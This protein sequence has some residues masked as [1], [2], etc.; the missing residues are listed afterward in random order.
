MI[1]TCDWGDGSSRITRVGAL[2]NRMEVGVNG[3]GDGT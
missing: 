3:G 2:D 1:K